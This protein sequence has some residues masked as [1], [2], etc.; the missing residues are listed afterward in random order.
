ME[1][2]FKNSEANQ[3]IISCSARL[4]ENQA[5]REN[6]VDDMVDETQTTSRLG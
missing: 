2:A 4:A 5:Q 3:G 6:D 1:L